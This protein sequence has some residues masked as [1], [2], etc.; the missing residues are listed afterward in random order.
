AIV[1]EPVPGPLVCVPDICGITDER[2][3]PE[4]AAYLAEQR[5]DV[6]LYKA[7]KLKGFLQPS[8]EGLLADIVAVLENDRSSPAHVDHCL[9]VGRNALRGSF[10]ILFRVGL[11]KLV[12]FLF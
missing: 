2:A 1:R 10:K 6:L 8:V 3:P 12:S 9:D 4:R 11:S 5:S 7:G